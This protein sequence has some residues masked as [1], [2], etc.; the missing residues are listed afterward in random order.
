MI[1]TER[2]E[3]RAMVRRVVEAAFGRSDEADLIDRIRAERAVLLSLV[4][5]RGDDIVGHILF[6]RMWIDTAD[7]EVPAVALAPLAV[8]PAHQRGGIGGS[9]IRQGLDA[10]RESG[11]SLV[12][13][14]GDPN[15]YSRFGFSIDGARLLGSPFPQNALMALQLGR[16][17]SAPNANSTGI[18]LPRGTVRYPAAFGL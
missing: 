5:R 17:I 1:A 16:G 12:V 11:E 14:L 6:S 7:G 15:Y 10:L 13:V 9:L 8:L 18:A 2:P 4:A 3:H